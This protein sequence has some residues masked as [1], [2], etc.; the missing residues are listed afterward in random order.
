MVS[1]NGFFKRSVSLL[2]AVQMVLG[3]VPV[4][5]FAADYEEGLCPHHEAHTAE[6]GYKEAVEASPCAFF[7]QEC[8][9][10]GTVV[11]NDPQTEEPTEETA[12]STEET[13]VG[14][15]IPDTPQD[16]VDSTEAPSVEAIHDHEYVTSVTAPTC[17]E[18]GYTTYTCDLCGH[19]YTDNPVEAVGHDFSQSYVCAECGSVAKVSILGD[20]ISTYSGISSVKNA[21]YPNATVKSVEDTWW[22]QVINGLGAQLLV[23]NASGGS[24]VLS[25]EYFNGGGIR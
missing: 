25:D 9:T 21:V 14:G 6:C 2:L 10:V 23:N 20:S 1:K 8:D 15:G 12:E 5:T 18:Q 7:C 3:N 17:T 4:G 11:P 13:I 19:S 24:R 16:D 22:K